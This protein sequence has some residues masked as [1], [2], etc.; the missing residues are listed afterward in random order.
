MT[1]TSG[2]PLFLGLDSSTQSLKASVI[3]GDLKLVA[4]YAVNFDADLPEFKTSGGVHRGPD[5]LTVT[6]P[7]LLWVAA[8]DLLLARMK[9]SGFSF[10]RVAAG[11]PSTLNWM[12]TGATALSI[13]QGVGAAPAARSP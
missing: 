12:V 3:D 13:D 10:A 9:D 7:P 4:E 2:R 11:Q 6:S 5:G 8:L 1:R